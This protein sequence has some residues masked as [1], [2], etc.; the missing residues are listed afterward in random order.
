MLFSKD[1]AN[2]GFWESRIRAQN[3]THTE[4]SIIGEGGID[5]NSSAPAALESSHDSKKR[6]TSDKQKSRY[7]SLM[8]ISFKWSRTAEE[9]LSLKRE[10]KNLLNPKV[11][12]WI[13]EKRFVFIK[14]NWSKQLVETKPSQQLEKFSSLREIYWSID[15]WIILII[16]DRIGT[17]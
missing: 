2:I 16:F 1:Q 4:Y 3:P 13:G 14:L 8:D 6:R 12:V 17:R 11:F 5:N 9:L 7:I 10:E 15:W